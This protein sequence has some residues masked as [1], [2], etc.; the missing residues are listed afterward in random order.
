MSRSVLIASGKGGTGK[1][2]F[3]ANAGALLAMKD[4]RQLSWIWIWVSATLIFI[5]V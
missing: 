1:T 5:W 2:F 4:I 3:A